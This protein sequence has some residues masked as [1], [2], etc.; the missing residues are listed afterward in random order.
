MSTGIMPYLVPAAELLA[1]CGSGDRRLADEIAEQQP[2]RLAELDERFRD[3]DEDDD[4]DLERRETLGAIVEILEGN[5]R[6]SH[7]GHVYGYAFECI[8]DQL[9]RML[10]NS[11]VGGRSSWIERVDGNLARL[12]LGVRLERLI[13]RGPPIRLPEPDDYPFIGY[14]TGAEVTEAAGAIEGLDLSTPDSEE[15][16]ALRE[17]R[18]WL[19]AARAEPGSMIVGVCY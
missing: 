9:G 14:W 15:A 13:Y 12:G 3:R 10:P 8:C 16:G 11:Y 17:I 4:R 6:V 19:D 7:L 18:G 2:G 5:P 1:A